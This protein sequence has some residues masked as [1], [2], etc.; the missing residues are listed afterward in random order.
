M[1]QPSTGW[2]KALI[3]AVLLAATALAACGRPMTANETV[4]MAVIYPPTAR[5]PVDLDRIRIWDLGAFR[6]EAIARAK[7]QIEEEVASG[8]FNPRRSGMSPETFLVRAEAVLAKPDAITVGY[9]IFFLFSAN[10]YSFFVED[11]ALLGHEVVHVWQHQ[12]RKISGYSLAKILKEHIDY[13]NPYA[14]VLEPGKRFLAYRYEQQGKIVQDYVCMK[15]FND[16]GYRPREKIIA[17]ALDTRQLAGIVD[18]IQQKSSGKT[19]QNCLRAGRK[20]NA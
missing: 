20:P 14:Y 2:R 1:T 3:G 5:N 13:P 18:R 7:R 12:N 10:D 8:E 15:A 19:M 9:D 16:A 11:E 6:Q 4:R 17:E